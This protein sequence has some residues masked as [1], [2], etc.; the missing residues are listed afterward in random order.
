MK[1]DMRITCFHSRGPKGDQNE[2]G[3]EAK[4]DVDYQLNRTFVIIDEHSWSKGGLVPLYEGD[5]P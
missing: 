1:L 2:N 3:N 4:E 5:R